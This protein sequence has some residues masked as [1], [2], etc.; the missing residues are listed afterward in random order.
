VKLVKTA[1]GRYHDPASNPGTNVDWVV[2]GPNGQ[3]KFEVRH[4]SYPVG[5][6]YDSREQASAVLDKLAEVIAD[7]VFDVTASDEDEQEEA[8]EEEAAE[9]EEPE[10]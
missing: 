5:G 4:G 2:Y 3:D 7:V 1:D 10:P 6:P 8:A 9:E